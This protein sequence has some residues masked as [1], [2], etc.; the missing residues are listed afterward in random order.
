MLWPSDPA[1]LDAVVEVLIAKR[2]PIVSD[3]KLGS[4]NDRPQILSTYVM[5]HPSA[6]MMLLDDTRRKL[7]EY[8]GAFSAD[9]VPQ[10]A[11]LSHL[12]RM[13]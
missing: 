11:V 9:W 6:S 7:I 13:I 4:S 10:Q 12:V 2:I 3:K 1:K 8:D 5:T